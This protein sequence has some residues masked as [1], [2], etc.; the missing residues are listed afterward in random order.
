MDRW[1]GRVLWGAVGL[2]LAMP[3]LWLAILAVGSLGKG[4]SW[5]EMD[6]NGDGRTSIGEFLE[7]GDTFERETIVQG[8]R[9]VEIVA[10]KD[11]LP[12]RTRCSPRAPA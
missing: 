7:T 3:V 5:R 4:Y 8:R 12:L 6:W 2:V 1:I 9:C 11:G 10:M